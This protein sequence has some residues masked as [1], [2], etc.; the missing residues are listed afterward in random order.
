MEN[1]KEFLEHLAQKKK[2]QD[3]INKCTSLLEALCPTLKGE[4]TSSGTIGTFVRGLYN[5]GYISINDINNANQFLSDYADFCENNFITITEAIRDYFYQTFKE[6]AQNAVR[7]FK[8]AI[9]LIPEDVKIAPKHLGPLIQDEFIEAF[10]AL[11][12][13]I[14]SIYDDIER[15]PFEWG[16]PDHKTKITIASNQN[17]VMEVLYALAKSGH[18]ESNLLIVNKKAFNGNRCIKQMKKP[19]SMLEGLMN[20]GFNFENLDDKKSDFF[21]VSHLDNPHITPVLHAYFSR[22]SHKCYNGCKNCSE[23]CTQYYNSNHVHTFSYR[24]VED[25]LSQT[26]DTDILVLMDKLPEEQRNIHYWLCDE[27]VKHGF[28]FHGVNYGK[29]SFKKSPKKGSKE[30]LIMDSGSNRIQANFNRVFHAHR[31]KADGLVK[32]FPDAFTR[33]ERECR[34]CIGETCHAAV[35]IELDGKKHHSCTYRPYYFNNPTLDDVKAILEL[36]KLEN[37]LKVVGQT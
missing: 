6:Q 17:R 7:G 28:F 19:K 20:M 29:I 12:E 10:R 1:K 9:I 36:Y 16:Y 33:E 25:P 4:P 34:E 8:K 31:D 37:N 13:V 2:K 35:N 5:H 18:L 23:N 26:H 32:R 15:E 22:Q 11:Q 30:W 24:Y 3:Y 27:A 14:I 21:E